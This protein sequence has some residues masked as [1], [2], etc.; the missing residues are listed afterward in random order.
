[1]SNILMIFVTH[2]FHILNVKEFKNKY[3]VHQFH[4]Q[5]PQNRSTKKNYDLY[6]YNYA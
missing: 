2:F 3:I 6:P 5:P 4:G 1:M